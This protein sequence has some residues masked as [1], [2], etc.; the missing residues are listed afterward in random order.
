MEMPVT[1]LGDTQGTGSDTAWGRTPTVLAVA[2]AAGQEFPMS[3]LLPSLA[4]APGTLPE[5]FPGLFQPWAAR[6]VPGLSVPA[7]GSAP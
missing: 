6:D 7:Q 2:E 4:A 5:G 3:L 1:R